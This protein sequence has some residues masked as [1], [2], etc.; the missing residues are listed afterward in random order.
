LASKTKVIKAIFYSSDGADF[1]LVV[2]SVISSFSASTLLRIIQRSL[3]LHNLVLKV[4]R[5][6]HLEK[7][8]LFAG[9]AADLIKEG[10]IL[11]SLSHPNVLSCWAWSPNGADSSVTGRHNTFFLVLNR[12]E[13]T[14]RRLAQ[15]AISS[16]TSSRANAVSKI[17]Q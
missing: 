11:A 17:I 10:I 1:S 16:Q 5:S 2:A 3:R 8:V 14:T 9:C 7:P 13:E 15:R 6:K 12:I 4:L